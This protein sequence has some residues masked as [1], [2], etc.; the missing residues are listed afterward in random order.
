MLQNTI[1]ETKDNILATNMLYG[2]FYLLEDRAKAKLLEDFIISKE[3][4]DPLV[5]SKAKNENF[6]L[7][8]SE[9][10]KINSVQLENSKNNSNVEVVS[11]IKE[12]E[13]SV[14]EAPSFAGFF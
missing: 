13:K 10:F 14:E 11:K 6:E 5:Y 7:I 3:I 8:I 9:A 1:V 2:S 4:V 12:V